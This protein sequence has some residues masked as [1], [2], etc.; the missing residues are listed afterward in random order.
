[1][2]QQGWVWRLRRRREFIGEIFGRRVL[3]LHR[4]RPP[5]PVTTES[6]IGALVVG[7]DGERRLKVVEIRCRLSRLVR[8]ARIEVRGGV[9]M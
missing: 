5:K 2:A 3:R 4:R 7:I 1:M 8:V 6:N 9:V